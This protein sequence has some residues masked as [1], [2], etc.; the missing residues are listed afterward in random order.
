MEIRQGEAW[1]VIIRAM[2][3]K[4]ILFCGRKMQGQD[5]C[6]NHLRI[7]PIFLVN[8]IDYFVD[9]NYFDLQQ[10]GAGAHRL[11]EFA[12]KRAWT[13]KAGVNCGFATTI[14]S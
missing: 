2:R 10:T 8:K 11:N 7:L 6:V 12:L 9:N 4:G 1:L 5:K 13:G 14:V 3:G